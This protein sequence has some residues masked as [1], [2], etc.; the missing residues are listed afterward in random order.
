MMDCMSVSLLMNK[1][2]TPLTPNSLWSSLVN[3]VASSCWL[4]QAGAALPS[5]P[6]PFSCLP[7]VQGIGYYRAG[8][9]AAPSSFF[10]WH[11]AVQSLEA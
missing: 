7:S 6:A 1:H 9:Q 4:P 10:L 5:L 2:E 3:K 11:P 8:H